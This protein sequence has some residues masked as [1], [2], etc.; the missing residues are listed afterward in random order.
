MAVILIIDDEGTVAGRMARTLERGGHLAVVAPDVRS[1]IRGAA[2]KPEA[3]LLDLGLSNTPADALLRS[4]RQRP[5]L[6]HTPVLA[7]TE[8]MDEAVSLRRASR[9]GFSL[10]LH[11][12]VSDASL[13]LAI[14]AAV[15]GANGGTWPEGLEGIPEDDRHA[16][17]RSLIEEG[18]EWLALEAYRRIRLGKVSLI[19]SPNGAEPL[20]WSE[21]LGWVRLLGLVEGV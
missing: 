4:L 1:A 8:R 6:L 2:L 21:I 16:F 18:P 12:P 19:A 13:C 5:E 10:V 11:K 20:G 3:I 15:S 14:W 17:L 7:T 9:S